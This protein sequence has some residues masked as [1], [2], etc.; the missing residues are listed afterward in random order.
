MLV[1][2]VG[3]KKIVTADCMV[4]Q[5]HSRTK[6]NHTI[7]IC[8][9]YCFIRGSQKLVKE[10]KIVYFLECAS[11]TGGIIWN[12]RRFD[13]LSNLFCSCICDLGEYL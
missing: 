8:W 9:I 2:L 3:L 5:N 1:S 13:G 11:S 7:F 10:K 6:V 12:S 4:Y